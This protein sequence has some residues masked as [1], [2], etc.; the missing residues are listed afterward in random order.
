MKTKF[1]LLLSVLV[2]LCFLV[3]CGGSDRAT[4]ELPTDTEKNAEKAAIIQVL[5]NYNK[6]ANDRDW[7]KMVQ[8]LADKV[9]FYGTDSGEVS[10]TFDEFKATIQRQWKN[11]P[12]FQYGDV[13][14]VYIE[15]DDYANY[16]N[17]IYN[18]HLIYAAKDSLPDTLYVLYQRMLKK[19]P[20][21][22]EWK[23]TSG[24]TA[25]SRKV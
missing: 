3:A 12:V 22:K 7:E 10:R 20:I 13:K 8:T 14:N 16:V 24:I 1:L 9:T 25:T 6:A 11:Y 15:M 2:G 21:T 17:V 18:S 4:D 5:N 19:D 23:I